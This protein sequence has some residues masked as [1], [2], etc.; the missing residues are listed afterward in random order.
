MSQQFNLFDML[1]S[2]EERAA[3]KAAEEKKEE[4]KKVEEEKKKKKSSTKKKSSG[5]KSTGGTASTSEEIEIGEEG[6]TVITGYYPEKT[7]LPSDFEKELEE[8]E[9]VKLSASEVIR[10]A[11]KAGLESFVEGNT[12]IAKLKSGKYLM[13]MAGG[14]ILTDKSNMSGEYR[15]MLGGYETTVGTE[16]EDFGL[17]EVQKAWYDAYPD[18]EKISDFVADDDRKVIV[19]IFK[20]NPTKDVKEGLIYIFGDKPFT[21]ENESL[22]AFAKKNYAEY[23]GNYHIVQ[24]G[25]GEYFLVPCIKTGTPAKKETMYPTSD[26]SISLVFSK[27]PLSPEMFDGKEEVTEKEL[28][29]YISEDFPEFG[30][31]RASVEYLKKEKLIL[32]SIKSAKKGGF[33]TTLEG[34]SE[35][36]I[37]EAKEFLLNDAREHALYF[38]NLNL[39]KK[40]TRRV[41]LEKTP[42][43]TFIGC[44]RRAGEF[45]MTLP[46]I[47]R[48]IMEEIYCFFLA[49]KNKMP[50]SNEAAAQIF[51]DKSKKKYFVYY[52][53]QV[54]DTVSVSFERSMEL[55]H[56][57]NNVLVMDVHSH[58][59]IRPNFS[60]VD[61][62]DEKGTRLFCVLGDM[63]DTT[64]YHFSLRAGT[65]GNFIQV[66]DEDV[67]EDFYD[68]MYTSKKVLTPSRMDAVRLRELIA[69]RV[70]FK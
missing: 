40:P 33:A 50:R 16:G 19:P 32:V 20:Q 53:Q 14:G 36:K 22:E 67:F 69:D 3:M 8:G 42:V 21:F 54:V 55:E 13:T 47:P 38:V 5:S 4:E 48:Y 39:P 57:S 10:F 9:T 66:A 37:L 51:W 11:I 7:L 26:V 25:E 52:P 27:I 64:A 41:R 17:K 34:D 60:A 12:K 49:V 6:I 44:G 23:E 1:M 35:D 18:F 2:E 30:N 28:I 61:D 65:G 46:K 29:E 63:S 70:V 68:G 31:G 59:V 56:D 62:N 15:I 45:Q 24:Y 58:G 43:G